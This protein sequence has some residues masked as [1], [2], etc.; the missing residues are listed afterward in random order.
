MKYILTEQQLTS[1]IK[2]MIDRFIK[3]KNYKI[4]IFSVKYD[5]DY[6]LD[7]KKYKRANPAGVDREFFIQVYD[8]NFETH[9]I[10]MSI[11]YKKVGNSLKVGYQD[12]GWSAEGSG[13]ETLGMND[14]V[15]EYLYEI[16][17]DAVQKFPMEIWR[18]N[19][20][21]EYDI[22]KGTWSKISVGL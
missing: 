22:N 16:L 8:P 11:T 12:R 20:K 21:C 18:S 19:Y 13:F 4:V 17:D 7:G 9:E 10:D 14:L 2:S 5:Q 1:A 6:E 15:D 3:L